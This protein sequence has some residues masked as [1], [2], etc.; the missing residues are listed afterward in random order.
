M[1]E[2]RVHQISDSYTTA[3]GDSFELE[4]RELLRQRTRLMLGVVLVVVAIAVVVDKF[5]VEQ[6]PGLAGGFSPWRE[7]IRFVFLGAFGMALALTY[8]LKCTARQ[9]QML[10]FGVV[11]IAMV[12]AIFLNA[13]V[14]PDEEPILAVALCLFVYAAFIPSPRRFPIILGVLALISFVMAAVMT[15]AFVEGAE[16][17]WAERGSLLGTSA[18]AVLRNHLINGT[19]SIGILA[20]VAHAVSKTLYSLRKTA[21][22]AERLGNY[23]VEEELGAGGMGQVFRARHALIRR[24]TAVKVMQV[25][26]QDA[27][28]AVTRFEREVQLSATLTHPNSITIYDFGRTPDNRFYYVMEYLEGLD[29]QKLV[30]RFGPIPPA[31]SVFILAQA[32]SALGE[33]HG[34]GIVHRDIK[35]SN[36]FLTQRGGLYDFVKVLDFGLA[37]QVSADDAAGL[38]KTGVAVGTPRYISPE[39]IKGTEH[40]DPRSD[41]YC[42]G[43]VAYWMLTGRPPFEAKSSVELLIDHVKATPDRPSQVTEVQIPPELDDIVMTC[44]EKDPE[45]RFPDAASLEAA[46]REL[47][48]GEPWT[49]EKALEWW[50]LHGLASPEPE[51]PKP[52]SG[53]LSSTRG[54]S[55]FIFEP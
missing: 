37:K 5:L 20:L 8:L 40:I 28:A 3:T 30:E 4:L 46:L 25:S 7:E 9:F 13:S 16:A 54:I 55:R 48:F 11:A 23:Y 21:H 14:V 35:P 38:T 41:L 10:A 45:D 12:L 18:I 22:Q 34:R 24:P 33:A 15:F 19:V 49:A 42:L 6:P 31:R 27:Q 43:A 32:C 26:G 50:N 2:L 53:G 17:Y 51:P 47:P 39:A 36:I 52:T 1:D 29:L 44:L